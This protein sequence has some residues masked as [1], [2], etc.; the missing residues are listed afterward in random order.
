MTL[1]VVLSLLFLHDEPT[2]K[3]QVKEPGL[4]QEILARASKDQQL[5]IKIF[6]QGSLKPSAEDLQRLH[7]VDRDNRDY[8]KKVIARHGWP[9]KTLV[10]E[11]GAHM[12]WLLVQHADAD[13][14]FQKRC[15][16]LLKAAVKQ[17]EATAIDL[18]YLTDRILAAEG[19]KQR[20]GTQ[21]AEKEGKL[22]LKPVEDEANLDARRKQL[23]LPPIA[24]YIQDASRIYELNPRPDRPTWKKE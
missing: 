16:D 10:G 20:Y 11:D 5:R 8:L 12:T 3:P 2:T 22:I 23:G 6:T 1:L 4:R 9:G 18:A 21:L 17:G 15:L 7:E 19:K 24:R 14:P 13:L